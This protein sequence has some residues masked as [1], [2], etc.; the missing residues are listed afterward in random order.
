MVAEDDGN[1]G[2]TDRKDTGNDAGVMAPFN[3]NL[4][5]FHG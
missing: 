5:V 3:F 4:S 1:H 2:F